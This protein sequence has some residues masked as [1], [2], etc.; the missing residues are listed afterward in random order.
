MSD[1]Q[2]QELDG[3]ASVVEAKG[4]TYTELAE[5]ITRSVGTLQQIVDDT[6]TTAK[7]MEATRKLAGEVREDIEKARD[8]Y[9]FT[10][11]ALSTYGAALRGAK[12]EAD[13]AAEKLRTLRSEL[14]D[15]RA[16]ARNAESQMDDLPDSASQADKDDATRAASG[17]NATVSGLEQD[18]AVQESYWN[19]GHGDKNSAA[20]TAM[21][22]IEEVVS[23]DKV[24]GLEDSTWDKVKNVAKGI[25]KVFKVICD[26]AGILAIFLSWVPV[27]GQILMVLAAIGAILSI[28]ENIVKF[29]RGE[30]GFGAML[31]GVGLGVMGLFGGKAISSVA[32]YAKARSVVQTA[33]RMSNGAAKAKFGTAVLKSSRKTFAL[34]RGQRV[35][36]VLKSPFVRT[37]GDKAV[38]GMVRNGLYKNAFTSWRGSQFPLP[39]K[40]GAA[41]FAMGNDD[42]VD[43]IG[44]FNQTGLRIDSVTSSAQAIATVGAVFNQTANLANNAAKLGSAIGGGDGWGSY[45]GGNS[46]ATSGAGGSWGKIT[47]LPV[48]VD[49][50]VTAVQDVFGNDGYVAGSW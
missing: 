2:W 11:E 46:L 5:A 17:A 38:A 37:A 26:I 19:S 12:N 7:S 32:K 1:T 47:G 50:G 22:K 33:S 48:N 10:G 6:T 40:D 20:G 43:M 14:E 25:Y 35:T 23:G 3:E 41:R 29:A 18:I 44:H 9:S 8:R 31:L 13:P 4:R 28:V 36:E 49:K 42:V 34:T 27:L 45:E 39:Y 16:V 24:H 30:I 15:A 21:S